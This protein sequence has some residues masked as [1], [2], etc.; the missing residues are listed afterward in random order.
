V[1]VGHVLTLSF[2]AFSFGQTPDQIAEK[3]ATG[4]AIVVAGRNSNPASSDTGV[5]V[6]VRANGILLTPYHVIRNAPSVQVRLRTGEVFNQV[7]LLGVDTLRDIAAI[8]VTGA[9]SPVTVASSSEIHPGD[10]VSVVSGLASPQLSIRAG[11]VAGYRMANEIAGAGKGYRVIQLTATLSIGSSG[12]VL[13]DS[14]GNG[15]GL[16]L[17]SQP[18]GQARDFAVPLDSVLGLADA[19]VS[20][21]FGSGSELPPQAGVPSQAGPQSPAAAVKPNRQEPKAAVHTITSKERQATLHNLQT[22]YIDAENA[23]NISSGEVKAALV[24]DPA[25]QSLNLRLVDDPK[26]AD[27]IFVIRRAIGLEYPFEL[28]SRDRTTELL[29]GKSTAATSKMAV[30]NLSIDFI[31]ITRPYRIK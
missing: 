12:A 19:A 30:R 8:Q 26:D 4:L 10:T 20:R 5:A 13:L 14:R 27:A 6:A 24:G 23:K 29:S 1:Q 15:L 17:S 25:F 18:N 2:A 28:M 16:M 21:T 22:I 7:Q 31:K 9:L 11:S 3:T